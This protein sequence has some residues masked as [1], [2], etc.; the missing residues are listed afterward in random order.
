M[1]GFWFRV[2]QKYRRGPHGVFRI[3]ILKVK[4]HSQVAKLC[5][6]NV[7]KPL[8]DVR[9]TRCI[10]FCSDQPVMRH[11]CMQRP[12]TTILYRRDSVSCS[13]ATTLAVHDPRLTCVSSPKQNTCHSG[14]ARYNNGRFH[15][16]ILFIRL[17]LYFEADGNG[18]AAKSPV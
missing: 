4:L 1:F 11:C 14:M 16:Y 12:V 3:C 13:Q 6:K 8:G 9:H 7:I 5:V 10:V 2:Y 15:Y 18:T 17:P